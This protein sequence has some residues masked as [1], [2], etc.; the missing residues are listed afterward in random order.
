MA[1]GI[2]KVILVGNLGKDPEVQYLE[3]NTALARFSVATSESYKNKE[4]QRIDQTEWHNVVLWRGLAEVAEK[5]LRKGSRVYIEGK[6]KT[7]SWDDKDGNKKYTTEIIGDNMVML[8]SKN[9]GQQGGYNQMTPPPATQAAQ[10][11]GKSLRDQ[12][13]ANTGAANEAKSADQM[14]DDL[15]F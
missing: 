5:F 4:G 8:D 11:A 9:D 13:N 12:A 7:R 6:I 2:N 15:P 1:R 3:S 14:E 10:D